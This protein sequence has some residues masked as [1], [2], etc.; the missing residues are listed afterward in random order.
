MYKRIIGQDDLR[1]ADIDKYVENFERIKDK[2]MIGKR[3]PTRLHLE[4]DE[5]AYAME[6]T[7]PKKRLLT[8]IKS[9]W[10]HDKSR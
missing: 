1:Q 5:Q 10:S 9:R 8:A 3:D 6:E 2:L 4:D 7:L